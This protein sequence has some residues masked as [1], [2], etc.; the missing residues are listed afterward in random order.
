MSL[1]IDENILEMFLEKLNQRSE[2]CSAKKKENPIQY[3]QVVK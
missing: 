3:A 2:T 1:K